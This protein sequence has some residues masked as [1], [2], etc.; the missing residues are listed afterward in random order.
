L[1][2]FKD[3]RASRHDM[4][5]APPEFIDAASNKIEFSYLNGNL[6]VRTIRRLTL[7]FDRISHRRL[8]A[9]DVSSVV[10]GNDRFDDNVIPDSLPI[11]RRKVLSEEA[12]T[13]VSGEQG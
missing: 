4:A 5:H 13:R 7:T 9:D 3:R 10:N 1:D 12:P 6:V 8:K 2:F 11:T